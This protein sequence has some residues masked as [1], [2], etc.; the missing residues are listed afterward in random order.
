L[1]SAVLRLKK[2]RTTEAV[3]R[4]TSSIFDGFHHPGDGERTAR[5]ENRVPVNVYF[6][7][8]SRNVDRDRNAGR[9]AE[10]EEQGLRATNWR[11]K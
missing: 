2:P 6:S 10:C 4:A 1:R 8:T 5:I 11:A 3:V 9:A 7:L